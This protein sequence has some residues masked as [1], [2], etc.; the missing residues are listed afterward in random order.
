MGVFAGLTGSPS[1]PDPAPGQ[2]QEL[3]QV[4]MH[5]LALQLSVRL[6]DHL[7]GA[8]PKANTEGLNIKQKTNSKHS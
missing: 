1:P 5:W 8:D 7:L 3:F 2:K 6:L 4:P